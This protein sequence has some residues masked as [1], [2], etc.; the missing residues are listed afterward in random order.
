MDNPRPEKVAKVAELERRFDDA[1]A[2]LLTEYRGLD[3][4]ALAALRAELRTAGA[5]YKIYKNT[6]VR[7]AARSVGLDLD[8]QL[9]GPTAIAFVGQR[10]D[11]TPGDAAAAAK[12]LREFVRTHDALVLKGGVVDG[13]AVSVE[14]IK[15]LADLP[16]REVLLAQIAGALAAPMQ[17][18]AGLLQAMPRNLAYGI[19]ALIDTKPADAAPVIEESPAAE[20]TTDATPADAGSEEENQ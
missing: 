3:V 6:L 11:G 18:F 17:Q 15:V 14:Q 8:A 5:E 12:A 2:V 13:A 19:K 10:A 16:S 7:I 20:A 4:P 1:S 9:T